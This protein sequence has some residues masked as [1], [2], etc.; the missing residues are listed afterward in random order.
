MLLFSLSIECIVILLHCREQNASTFTVPLYHLYSFVTALVTV[1]SMTSWVGCIIHL[2]LNLRL[3][4]KYSVSNSYNLSSCTIASEVHI[5]RLKSSKTS[6]KW[7]AFLIP[8]SHQQTQVNLHPCHN[9][10]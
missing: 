4:T 7:G 3:L 8:N 9:Y 5:R 10:M 6:M 2:S 1:L